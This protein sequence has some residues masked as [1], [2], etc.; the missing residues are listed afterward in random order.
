[1]L[2]DSL[3]QELLLSY[4]LGVPERIIYQQMLKNKIIIYQQMLHNKARDSLTW[5]SEYTPLVKV[6]QDIPD[7]SFRQF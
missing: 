6:N 5:I 7:W 4:F 3:L 1:M 2:L